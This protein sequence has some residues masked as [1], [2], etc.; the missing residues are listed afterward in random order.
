MV[1]NPRRERDRSQREQLIVTTAR[2]IAEEEGWDAVTTRRLAAKIE[3]SQPVL[4]SHFSG[5]GAIMAA[6][7][8]EGC[9]EMAAHMRKGAG[10]AE[11]SRGA[12]RRLAGNYFDFADRKPALYDAIFTLAS[13]LDFASPDSPEPLKD[14]F[15]ALLEIVGPV[16][17]DYD[18]GLYTETFWAALHGLVTLE[19]S[20]RL[21][22]AAR[23]E[24]IGML[25]DRFAVGG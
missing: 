8:L 17:G 23:A 15:G 16:A 10:A 14:A 2:E 21:P 19:R 7:A 20:R 12:L 25:V 24:R 3:Y 9:T 11:D 4:Y 6:A 18:P 1:T 5:K 22:A 13:E